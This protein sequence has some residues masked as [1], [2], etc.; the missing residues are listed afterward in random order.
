VTGLGFL[1]R[2]IGYITIT[3]LRFVYKTSCPADRQQIEAVQLA[4]NSC[5]SRFS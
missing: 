3:P 2:A 4:S 5:P 1:L